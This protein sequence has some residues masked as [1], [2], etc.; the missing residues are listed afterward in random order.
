[1]VHR[2]I[3]LIRVTG[4]AWI[5]ALPDELAGQKA[6]MRRLLAVCEAD[7][8]IRWLAIGCSLGRGAADRLSDLD[9]ALGVRDEDFG[10]AIGD[11]RTAVDG[12][13]D[14]VDSYH[15]L[16]PEVPGQHERIFAQYADRCQLD[17]VV[18]LASVDIGRVPNGLVLYDQDD[19]IVFRDERTAPAPGQI[20]EWAFRGWCTLADLGKYLRRQS[21]WE[22]LDRLNEGR[23]QLW[24]L[25]A[26][27]RDVPDA[28]YGITSILDYAPGQVPAGMAAT[29]AGLDL[30]QLLGAAIELGRQLDGIGRD[31]PA[32]YRAVLP[33]AMAAYIRRDLESLAAE[34]A[35]TSPAAAGHAEAGHAVAG[36]AVAEPE[37]AGPESGRDEA[38]APSACT[39]PTAER[40]L[41]AAEFDELF[42]GAVLATDR[43]EARHLRLQ[44]R[45]DALVAGRA[46]ELAAAETA[47]CSFFTFTLTVGNDS[48]LLD[49]TVPDAQIGV[50]DALGRRAAAAAAA[51]GPGAPA[52]A[53]V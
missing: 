17:L 33:N 28:R 43:P 1:V 20:R 24:Q 48:L 26:A 51:A 42:G 37:R 27:A 7:D 29:V 5:D 53:G 32:E 18:F 45:P 13:A 11:I 9:M 14:L 10:A 40:P 30:D 19:K 39:L 35:G 31:L 15:H 41:R 16:L 46:A 23:A 4:H 47:C 50:L 49:I 25:Q 52:G 44:L 6:I 2:H 8:R 12:L 21:L 3:K 22:A 38:W 34:R 36:H